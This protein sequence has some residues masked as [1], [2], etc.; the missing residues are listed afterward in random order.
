MIPRL[1]PA[2]K[3][4]DMQHVGGGDGI[5]IRLPSGR[6]RASSRSVVLP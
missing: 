6:E 1:A 2:G 5:Q 4:A 3:A